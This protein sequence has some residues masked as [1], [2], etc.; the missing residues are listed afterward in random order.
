M[1]STKEMLVVIIINMF[2]LILMS[3]VNNMGFEVCLILVVLP[4]ARHIAS[5]FLS[6]PVFKM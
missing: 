2:H 1:I 3:G 5:L 4:W 6:F